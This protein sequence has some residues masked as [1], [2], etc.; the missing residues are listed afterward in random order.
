MPVYPE[1][2]YQPRTK[3]NDPSVVYD[4]EKSSVIFAEDIEKLDE[5]VVAIQEH[6]GEAPFV[7]EKTEEHILEL[8]DKDKTILFDVS[9]ND[10]IIVPENSAVAFPIGT[11]I[12]VM[13]KGAG[14]VEIEGDGDVE[15]KSIDGLLFS[16]GQNSLLVLTKIETDVWLLSGDV[17]DEVVPI[18]Q[19][20]FESGAYDDDDPI[21]WTEIGN[22]SAG[23]QVQDSHQSDR[24][25]PVCCGLSRK[26]V[27]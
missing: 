8:S 1:E 6:L 20:G 12:F 25:P 11:K 24:Q 16:N 3:E 13:Q 14:Q 7:L 5:N 17:G 10:K 22:I 18:T 27:R 21:T 15:I 9:E 19:D 2:I 23:L 4:E 26:S